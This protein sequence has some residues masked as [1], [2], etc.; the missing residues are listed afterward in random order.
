MK[1]IIILMIGFALLRFYPVYT[2][3]YGCIWHIDYQDLNTG[4]KYSE[5][6]SLSSVTVKVKE[7]D[8]N[9]ESYDPKTRTVQLT[10]SRFY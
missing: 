10:T 7:I 2:A 3:N 5:E 4:K 1:F 8:Y 9:Q 6:V